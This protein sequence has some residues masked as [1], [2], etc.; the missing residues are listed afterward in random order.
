MVT[1]LYVSLL[2][3]YGVWTRFPSTFVVGMLS[4]HGAYVV[5]KKIKDVEVWGGIFQA[6]HDMMYMS[7]NR[8]EKIDDFKE[9]GRVAVRKNFHK[10][11]PNDVWTN[12]F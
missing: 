4:K 7:I 3:S 2:R 8:G 9:H 6:L 12:Y 10:H 5:L 11:G 1:L